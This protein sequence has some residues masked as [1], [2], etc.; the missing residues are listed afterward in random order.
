M[1]EGEITPATEHA[2]ISGVQKAG[3]ESVRRRSIGYSRPS[4]SEMGIQSQISIKT[5]MIG[6]VQKKK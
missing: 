3:M 6:A 5:I 2:K 4:I 1:G